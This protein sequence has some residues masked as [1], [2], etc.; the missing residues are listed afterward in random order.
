[1]CF[2][3]NLSEISL[4]SK[5]KKRSKSFSDPFFVL[6]LLQICACMHENCISNFNTDECRSM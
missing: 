4:T 1:M 5:F 3:I 6:C 2:S